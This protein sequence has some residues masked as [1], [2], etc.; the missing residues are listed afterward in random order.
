MIPYMTRPKK[1]RVTNIKCFKIQ[2]KLFLISHDVPKQRRKWFF[3]T[4]K[5]PK[6]ALLETVAAKIETI[7]SEY[8]TNQD[9]NLF[10]DFKKQMVA[11]KKRYES[12]K[13]KANSETLQSRNL[14]NIGKAIPCHGFECDKVYHDDVEI[15]DLNIGKSKSCEKTTKKGEICKECLKAKQTNNRRRRYAEQAVEFLGTTIDTACNNPFE[16]LCSLGRKLCNMDMINCKRKIEPNDNNAKLL[17]RIE[18]CTDHQTK[19]VYQINSRKPS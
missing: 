18:R 15:V 11:A 6:K 9:E 4:E 14:F 12:N 10:K 17:I 8:V 2:N 3:L 7:E 5:K 16:M 19:M 13:K 1:E